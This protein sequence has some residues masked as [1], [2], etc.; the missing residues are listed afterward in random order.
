M[1]SVS[2]CQCFHILI[3]ELIGRIS[4]VPSGNDEHHNL[5]FM[6]RGEITVPDRD[7]EQETTEFSKPIQVTPK[8]EIPTPV[9]ANKGGL[10]VLMGSTGTVVWYAVIYV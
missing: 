7:K 9:P 10:I 5:L 8:K 1:V 2:C 4:V 6:F 3:L